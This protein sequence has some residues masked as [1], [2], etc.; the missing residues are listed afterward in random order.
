MRIGLVAFRVTVLRRSFCSSAHQFAN[1]LLLVL[2]IIS[3]KQYHTIL[4]PDDVGTRMD[5]IDLQFLFWD[6]TKALIT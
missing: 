3:G 1:E 5:D 4:E 6:R 2:E